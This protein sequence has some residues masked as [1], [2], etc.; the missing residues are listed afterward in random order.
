MSGRLSILGADDSAT[1]SYIML[2]VGILRKMGRCAEAIELCERNMPRQ[3]R[4][5]GPESCDMDSYFHMALCLDSVGQHQKACQWYDRSVLA[6]KEFCS[7]YDIH[8]CTTLHKR[9]LSLDAQGLGEEALEDYNAARDGYKRVLPA[10]DPD[11]AGCLVGLGPLTLL[12]DEDGGGFYRK[13][14]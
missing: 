4:V 10:D 8:L 14:V 12:P 5:L 3:E 13:C 1:I 7:P 6:Y 11:I 2:K 9:A